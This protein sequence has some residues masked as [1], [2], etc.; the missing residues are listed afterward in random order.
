M[1][2]MKIFIRKKQLYKGGKMAKGKNKELIKIIKEWQSLENDTIS[3]T[4]LLLNNTENS[5]VQVM[6]SIIRHDS[7]KRKVMLQFALAHMA[8]DAP[9]LSPR[10]LIPHGDSFEKHF[11][12]KAGNS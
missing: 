5:F 4:E 7:E 12:A 1:M 11:F 6:M 3:L 10:E 2:T 8:K 9:R